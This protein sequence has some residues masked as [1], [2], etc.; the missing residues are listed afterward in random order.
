VTTIR[1]VLIMTVLALAGC[2]GLD[3]GDHLSKDVAKETGPLI[4]LPAHLKDGSRE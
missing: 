3:F 4:T 2:S 1:C